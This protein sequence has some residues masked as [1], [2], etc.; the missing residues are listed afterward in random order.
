MTYLL[1]GVSM[2]FCGSYYA[3]HGWG[4]LAMAIAM[5]VFAV[6][7]AIRDECFRQEMERMRWDD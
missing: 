5:G 2:Y 6:A 7:S 4:R 1:A 3:H